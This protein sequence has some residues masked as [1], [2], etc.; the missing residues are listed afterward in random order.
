MSLIPKAK[1]DSEIWF[2]NFINSFIFNKM[3]GATGFEF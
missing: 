1:R 3:V 2:L